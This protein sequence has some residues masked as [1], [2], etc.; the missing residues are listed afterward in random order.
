M[1]ANLLI[2]KADILFFKNGIRTELAEIRESL[3]LRSGD[4]P[5]GDVNI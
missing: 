4:N 2:H 3:G 5:G 1:G